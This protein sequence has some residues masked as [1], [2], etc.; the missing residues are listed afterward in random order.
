MQVIGERNFPAFHKGLF[1]QLLTIKEIGLFFAICLMILALGL[2]EPRFLSL[3]NILNVARQISLLC[4]IAV[5]M[6]YCLIAGEFDLSVGSNFGLSAVVLGLII[7]AGYHP[8]LG[9]IVSLVVGTTIGVANGL[10]IAKVKI[11]S[12][13]V[14]LGTLSVIRGVALLLTEGWPVS[15]Y[16]NENI[17]EWFLF[18]GG[19][20]AFGLI[21]MQAVF[22]AIILSLGFLTL[23]KSKIG[24]HLFC[25][26][27]NPQA[28][29][30]YG[31]SV[32]NVKVFAFATTGFLSSL[33]GILAF[34]FIQTAEP[35]MGTL[36]ELEVIAAAVIGGTKVGGG[37]GSVLGVLLGAMT[38]GILNNGLVLLGISPFVQKIVLGTVIIAAVFLGGEIL[39][40]K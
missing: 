35:N 33:S 24:Y 17:G 30:L 40:K 25:V 3:I 5:G 22:M 34:S 26:G 10:L 27:G 7:T 14:T 20:K 21:P 29:M 12:F 13:V 28:S 32:A 18:L 37:Q 9:I 8:I 2:M 36:M 6:S 38:I 15:I 19:G 11:P 23:H 16:G 1:Q 4:I 31:I 39:R